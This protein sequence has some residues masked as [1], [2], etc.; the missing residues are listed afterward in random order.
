MYKSVFQRLYLFLMTLQDPLNH[1]NM[2]NM[3]KEQSLNLVKSKKSQTTTEKANIN[4]VINN[5][6]QLKHIITYCLCMCS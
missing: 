5:Q 2:F 6:L 1:Q 3:R 4:Y